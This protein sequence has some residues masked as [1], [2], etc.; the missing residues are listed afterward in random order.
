MK[1][2]IKKKPESD[3]KITKNVKMPEPD[4]KNTEVY[5]PDQSE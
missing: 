5:L 2:I 4:R 1:I 3:Q